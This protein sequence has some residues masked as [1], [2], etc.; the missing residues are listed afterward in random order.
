M[1]KSEI[2]NA[3]RDGSGNYYGYDSESAYYGAH[4]GV[5]KIISLSDSSDLD[6]YGKFFHTY[7]EGDSFTV[8]KDKFEFDSITA[9]V[10]VLVRAL[11]P[12][13]L[14]RSAPI[15]VWRMSTN[16]TAMPTCVRRT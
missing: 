9:T 8:A 4:I 12:I 5:G 11:P 7:T 3:L 14:M 13:R 6:V 2:D 16:L 10:C 1:L 15:T